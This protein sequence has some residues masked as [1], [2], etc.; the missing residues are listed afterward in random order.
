M[1]TAGTGL[2]MT[3]GGGAIVA[4]IYGDIQTI[5]NATSQLTDDKKDLS[6]INWNEIE[7]K[8]QFDQDN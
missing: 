3:I 6:K 2:V 5:E 4:N 1:V 8:Q 7:I